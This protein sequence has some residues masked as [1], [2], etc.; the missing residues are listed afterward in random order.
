MPRYRGTNESAGTLV[1]RLLIAVAKGQETSSTLSEKLGVSP[2][3]VNRYVRQLGEAGWRIERVG[4][5]THGDYCF[6]LR[7]PQITWPSTL[8]ADN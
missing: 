7:N 6:E 3:Q 8:E 4:A 1:G 5:W 2:R